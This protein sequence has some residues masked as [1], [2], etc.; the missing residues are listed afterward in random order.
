MS[1][2]NAPAPRFLPGAT[3]KLLTSS[4]QRTLHR[5]TPK[6]AY[7]AALSWERAGDLTLAIDFY[8]K[9]LALGSALDEPRQRAARQRV[10][11]LAKQLGRLDVMRPVGGFV[12]V[13]HLKREP[14]P[15]TF[16]LWPGRHELVIET[17]DGQTTREL[18]RVE[19]GQALRLLV[20]VPGSEKT[21]A[22]RPGP[23][24]KQ[25]AARPQ[26]VKLSPRSAGYSSEPGLLARA[27]RSCW[28]CRLFLLATTS[29]RADGVTRKRAIVLSRFVPGPTSLGAP[30]RLPRPRAWCSCSA[31][32]AVRR[33]ASSDLAL[34]PTSLRYRLR[35]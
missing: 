18:V 3:R 2:T 25:R 12:T 4:R 17:R 24:G 9:A 30:P 15:A 27:P 14:L 20:D 10:A 23:I 21:T 29:T 11:A 1:S 19:Q 5:R 16:Y 33:S 22:P 35:F 7:N 28:D 13:A 8:A 6:T 26:P 31:R 32:A 34:G